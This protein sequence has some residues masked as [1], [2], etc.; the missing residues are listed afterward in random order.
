MLKIYTFIRRAVLEM[1]KVL[2]YSMLA[3]VYRKS[4][5]CCAVWSQVLLDICMVK[6]H[7]LFWHY[8]AFP[9]RIG[10]LRNH[11]NRARNTRSLKVIKLSHQ[12]FSL[13]LDLTLLVMKENYVNILRVFYY[14]CAG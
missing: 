1:W 5:Q 3:E 9:G 13:P 4:A 10:E 12:S 2:L 7:S 8:Y 11:N 14:V 6:A